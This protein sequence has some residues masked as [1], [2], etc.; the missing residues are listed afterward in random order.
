LKRTVETGNAQECDDQVSGFVMPINET[1]NVHKILKPLQCA[2]L[3]PDVRKG[4]AF[5]VQSVTR[6]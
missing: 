4:F 1:R 5:P 6:Q 3:P 2:A